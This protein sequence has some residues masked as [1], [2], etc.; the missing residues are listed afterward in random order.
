MTVLE[1]SNIGLAILIFMWVWGIIDHY[2]NKY[3]CARYK[4]AVCGSNTRTTNSVSVVIR[5]LE[6]LPIF[7]ACLVQWLVNN[8]LQVIICTT[9][10]YLEKVSTLV[11]KII[12]EIKGDR[13]KIRIIVAEQG[14]RSQFMAG[15]LE[16]KGEIVATSDNHILWGPDYLSNILP[17]FDDPK[18]S[19][20]S[21]L[22]SLLFSSAPLEGTRLLIWRT[23]ATA[24]LAHRERGTVSAAIMLH[25]IVRWCWILPGTT[26]IYRTH[27]LQNP[28][29]VRSYLNDYWNGVKFDAGDDTW[30]S[31]YLLRNNWIIAAQRTE[32]TNFMRTVKRTSDYVCQILRWER[33][34]IQSYIR[35][36]T[37]IPQM[38][39]HRLIVF[40]TYER[41]AKSLLLLI[42]LFAWIHAFISHPHI[43]MG[44]LSYYVYHKYKDLNRFF[45]YYPTASH[46]SLLS[47]L[48]QTIAYHR[49]VRT[50]GVG[51]LP[52]PKYVDCSNFSLAAFRRKARP[53]VI[54]SP[55]ATL[56][57]YLSKSE[58]DAL[59][60][61][62]DAL[63]GARDVETP[64]G[65]MRVYEWGP[66][67]GR[68]VLL[69]H[70]LTTSSIAVGAIAHEL[71]RRGCRVMTFV[72]LNPFRLLNLSM[73]SN[74]RQDLWG[75][76]YTDSCLDLDHDIR[77][78]TA[79]IFLA[80]TSSH[81]SW[82]GDGGFGLVGC[83]LGGAISV[84]F[85]GYFPNM[86]N[87]LAL[88]VPAGLI[89][90]ERLATQM[91]ILEIGTLLLPSG[92]LE[93]LIMKRLSQ[94]LFE[95]GVNEPASSR[96]ERGS[97][98]SDPEAQASLKYPHITVPETMKWAM[99][100]HKGFYTSFMSTARHMQGTGQLEKWKLLRRREDRTL[101]IAGS[102]D[103]IVVAEELYEDVREAL[104]DKLDW[105]VLEGAHDITILKPK[106]IVDALCESWEIRGSIRGRGLKLVL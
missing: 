89:R 26:A 56:L 71:A 25:V 23:V 83:S 102:N 86:V 44:C 36:V 98:S 45:A 52:Y 4:P 18:L 63:P 39:K 29:F 90:K 77:L 59:P 9:Y 76:G 21:T 34:T 42:H 69:I 27:I 65:T 17:C 85:A 8:P 33:S 101:V 7:K 35:T 48:S 92:L 80:V 81:L 88:L 64:H 87:S 53:R 84:E 54:K 38:Y 95:N 67:D 60:Y 47:R 100:N 12:Q 62:P 19:L 66:E 51:I 3:Y 82:T 78:Y 40:K 74:T 79:Q 49:P 75:H 37:E 2:L 68:K 58:K 1:Q 32:E 61:P 72:K 55:I 11:R 50:P 24:R 94:P 70:G 20:I 10:E 5:T 14:A 104:G 105:R 106:E 96:K 13:T 93:K 41:L 99:Q 73:I 16:A 15:V 57:P 22:R 6:P 43:T 97:K 103:S 28:G 91:K 46:L 30:I 31:R